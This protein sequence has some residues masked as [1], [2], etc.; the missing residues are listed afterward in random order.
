MAEPE[1]EHPEAHDAIHLPPPSIW[2][3]LVAVGIALLLTGLIL[4]L[5]MVISGA[6]IAVLSI[7]F[8]IRDARRELKELPE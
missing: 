4:N 5:V 1:A 7:A 6:V 8:W 3:V 2:P